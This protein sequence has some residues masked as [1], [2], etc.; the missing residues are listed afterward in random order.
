[1]LRRVLVRSAAVP[2]VA[3]LAGRRL[4]HTAS[5]GSAAPKPKT[6]R[7]R[8]AARL[9]YGAACV[10]LGFTGMMIYQEQHPGVQPPPDPKK[11]TLVILGTG[12]GATSLL[13]GLKT[14]NF[15]VVVVSPK[16]YFL[17]TPLLPSCTVGTVDHRSVMQPIRYVTRHKKTAVQVLEGECTNIDPKTRTIVVEDNSDIR[18]STSSTT[19]PYDYLVVAVGAENQTFGIPGVREYACFLKEIWDAKKIRTRL[20]DCI[21][22]A[23]FAGQSEEEIQRLLHMVVVGGGPTG[24][25]YAAELH[26]FIVED[27][28]VWYPDIAGKV[29]ITLIEALPNVLPAFSKQLIDYTESTF[30]ENQIDVLTKTK[31]KT[32]KE[33]EITV[34]EP[35]GASRDIPYGLLVW[36][37]GNTS[38]QVVRNLIATAPEKQKQRRGLEVDEHLR[39]LGMDSVFALGDATATKYAP[40]AQ[41]ASQQGAYLAA[42]FNKLGAMEKDDAIS[43][44]LDT[45]LEAVKPFKYSHYASLAYIGSD[46]AI[47][48]VSFL[49]GNVS[50]GGVATYLFWRSVYLSN[51]F[52]TRNRCLV[53]SDWIK[54][55]LFGRDIGRD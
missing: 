26:D 38:R 17:F 45:R 43:P 32:V 2:V 16:N 1:M 20:M 13:K 23:A 36:A 5:S 33:R 7:L 12:W 22:T 11:K 6:S 18:G 47:A 49:N 14:E 40:T 25:E 34:E 41:V 54:R 30:K 46:K 44:D 3:R 4:A 8:M 35:N 51:L 28:S 9:A 39:A 10:S 48:D 15:N 21:E 55:T 50:A 27:L 53:A 37:T 52:S 42:V 24:V 19:L 29:K 31:V